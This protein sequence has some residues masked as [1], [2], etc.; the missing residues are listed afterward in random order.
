MADG[1]RRNWTN[2]ELDLIVS[3]YFAMLNEEARGI[4]FNKAPA[5]SRPAREGEQKSGLD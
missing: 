1:E 5:Q 4:P 3:D 2:E